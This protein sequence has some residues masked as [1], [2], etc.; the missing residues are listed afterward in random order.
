MSTQ[1]PSG[2]VRPAAGKAA[3][4]AAA[5]SS[6]EEDSG[7]EA[8]LERHRP[9]EMEERQRFL[10]YTVG[11]FTSYFRRVAVN[12]FYQQHVVL[13]KCASPPVAG[14]GGMLACPL[15]GGSEFQSLI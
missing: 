3:A 14:D 5:G 1:A 15:G 11:G 13:L 2:G 4:A 6:S 7:D 10:S 9:L 8:F 12:S